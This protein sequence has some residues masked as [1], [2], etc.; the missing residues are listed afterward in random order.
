[1]NLSELEKIA[2]TCINGQWGCG[3]PFLENSESQPP[4]YR[5]L[6]KVVRHYKPDIV[7]ECGTYMA[8]SAVHMAIANAGTMVITIDHAPHSKAYSALAL[9]PNINLLLGFSTEARIF[10]AVKEQCGAKKIGLLFLDSEHDGITATQEFNTYS[11]LFAEECLVCADDVL[12]HRMYD[13]WL[14]MP[15]EKMTMN[16]LHPA[17]YPGMPDAGFGISIIRK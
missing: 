4:Y 16:F 15:G 5:F 2:T 3:D 14:G 8:T 13:F 11:Q 10:K 9:Y 1:M 6:N 17:Q 12:D 7:V